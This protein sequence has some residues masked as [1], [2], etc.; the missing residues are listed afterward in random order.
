MRWYTGRVWFLY[1][2]R[3]ISDW[4]EMTCTLCERDFYYRNVWSLIEMRW[5]LFSAPVIFTLGMCDFWLNWNDFCTLCLCDF[6]PGN[7]W[8]LIDKR[9][10]LPMACTIFTLE[11]CNIW[12]KWNVFYTVHLWF[13]H[14]ACVICDWNEMTF[15]LCVCDFYTGNVWS[16]IEM[17]WFLRF[18]CVILHWACVISDWNEMIFTLLMWNWANFIAFIYNT[19]HS[20]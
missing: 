18:A 7:V 20:S 4:N 14:W 10:I 13:L 15:T 6:F 3:V 12:L 5:F 1:W 2:E 17:R 16:P 8:C 19:T 11:I 9:W